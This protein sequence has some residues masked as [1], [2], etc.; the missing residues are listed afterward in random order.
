MYL[1]S[2]SGHLGF[3]TLF[4]WRKCLGVYVQNF[5]Y[6]PNIEKVSVYG[7]FLVLF[8]P[9]KSAHYKKK[10]CCTLHFD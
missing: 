6:D 7:L 2:H 9:I 10:N 1:L 3:M 8:F 5:R 4:Y